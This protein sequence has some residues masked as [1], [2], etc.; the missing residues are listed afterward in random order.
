[1]APEQARGDPVDARCDLFSLGVLLYRLCCGQPAFPGKGFVSTLL[2]V[3]MHQPVQAIQVNPELPAELSDLVMQLLQK[4][5]DRRPPS[6]AAV[7]E[8]LQRLQLQLEAGLATP[9]PNVPRRPVRPAARPRRLLVVGGG[10]GLLAALAVAALLLTRSGAREG[11][12]SGPPGN[13]TAAVPGS[14]DRHD[15][16]SGNARQWLPVPAAGGSAI[17]LYDAAAGALVRTLQGLKGSLRGWA[18]S[19]DESLLAM[20]FD[21]PPGDEGAMT[22]LRVW[23]LTAF[24]E[25]YTREQK[26]AGRLIHVLSFSPDGKSLVGGRVGPPSCIQVWGA[27]T[28]EEVRQVPTRNIYVRFRPDGK[29]GVFHNWIDTALSIWD[30]ETWQEVRTLRGP[31]YRVAGLHFSPDGQLLACAGTE[32]IMVWKSDD[33]QEVNSFAMPCNWHFL[34]LADNHSVLS[35]NPGSDVI[36]LRTFTS[37]DVLT[38]KQL[39][40]FVGSA[41][42]ARSDRGRGPFPRRRGPGPGPQRECCLHRSLPG[43]PPPA[44]GAERAGRIIPG[45]P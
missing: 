20:V 23:D 42:M 26:G 4:D 30:L 15:T 1:M 31:G 44:S 41:S 16:S 2:A 21:L 17:E 25:L 18:I 39:G 12:V 37:W 33:F 8:A 7:V 10:L 29:Q 13:N 27:R 5:P 3:A 32:R 40:T 14:D 24:R 34:F 6:A 36:P 43:A 22:Q 19:P 35:R 28:G 38:G 45:F 9:R 11:P